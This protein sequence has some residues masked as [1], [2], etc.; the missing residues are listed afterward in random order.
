MTPARFQ[1]LGRHESLIH[2]GQETHKS[3]TSVNGQRVT[4]THTHTHWKGGSGLLSWIKISV[5]ECVFGSVFVCSVMDNM[6]FGTDV[7][8]SAEKLEL[9][10]DGHIS[11]K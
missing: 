7:S 3:L 6:T 2:N 10:I 8:Q 5:S 1:R 4:Y 11:F 9:L